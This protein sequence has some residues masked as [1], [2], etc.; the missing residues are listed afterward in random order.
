MVARLP[1]RHRGASL[2]LPQ[3]LRAVLN[4]GRSRC[5]GHSVPVPA[6]PRPAQ[7]AAASSAFRPLQ[8]APWT[9]YPRFLPGGQSPTLEEEEGPANGLCNPDPQPRSGLPCTGS[10]AGGGGGRFC[11]DRT[12]QKSLVQGE[13]WARDL[14]PPLTASVSFIF[15]SLS[16]L[17]CRLGLLPNLSHGWAGGPKKTTKERKRCQLGQ[18]ALQILD[19]ISIK[20]KQALSKKI[21]GW[22]ALRPPL[23]HPN[24]I[25]PP[26]PHPQTEAYCAISLSFL[27][28]P[29]APLQVIQAA[30]PN[31][32]AKARSG[33]ARGLPTPC[34][35]Q[36]SRHRHCQRPLTN[37]LGS[38]GAI[39]KNRQGSGECGAES[40]SWGLSKPQGSSEVS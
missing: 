27:E 7:L 39:I 14:G 30:F 21:H 22:S 36:R 4:Y 18:K 13:L 2:P 38:C 1:P 31:R 40:G 11:G 20:M 29:K 35:A 10:G 34:W 16:F 8:A 32:E 26:T 37:S 6:L 28:P 24:I 12:C 23:P 19:G 33:K 17:T 5:P 25:Q 9:Q 15:L 3:P